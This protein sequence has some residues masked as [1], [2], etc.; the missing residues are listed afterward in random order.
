M[1]NQSDIVLKEVFAQSGDFMGLLRD[2]SP[3]FLELFAKII[4][5]G[6]ENGTF[7]QRNG[8]IEVWT[9]VTKKDYNHGKHVKMEVVI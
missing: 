7:V 4:Q 9:E 5:R 2:V 8:V 1:V 3:L 6:L